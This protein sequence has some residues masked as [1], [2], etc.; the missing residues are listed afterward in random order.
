MNGNG[1]EKLEI[2]GFE[3]GLYVVSVFLGKEVIKGRFVK[4]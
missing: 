3:V 1:L 2:E 4:I